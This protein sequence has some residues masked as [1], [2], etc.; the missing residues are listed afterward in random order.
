MSTPQPE[1]LWEGGSTLKLITHVFEIAL[2]RRNKYE[3]LFETLVVTFQQDAEKVVIMQDCVANAEAIKED[4]GHRRAQVRRQSTPA[5]PLL[6]VVKNIR[7]RKLQTIKATKGD[8]EAEFIVMADDD[9]DLQEATGPMV[10]KTPLKYSISKKYNTLSRVMDKAEK[11]KSIREFRRVLFSE[12]EVSALEKEEAE[13]IM[14]MQQEKEKKQTDKRFEEVSIQKEN[15]KLQMLFEIAFRALICE[16]EKRMNLF[17]ADGGMGEIVWDID[18]RNVGTNNAPLKVAATAMVAEAIQNKKADTL[19]PRALMSSLRKEHTKYAWF[20][21]MFLTQEA[22]IEKVR[23]F[24]TNLGHAVKTRLLESQEPSDKTYVSMLAIDKDV[25]E[26]KITPFAFLRARFEEQAAEA[27]ISD[28]RRPPVVRA[29]NQGQAGFT[30]SQEIESAV[31]ALIMKLGPISKSPNGEPKEEVQE[32]IRKKIMKTVWRMKD[33]AG[34]A[35]AKPKSA[36]ES[37]EDSEAEEMKA[38]QKRKQKGKESPKE[39]TLEEVVRMLKEQKGKLKALEQGG[40][41]SGDRK[42]PYNRSDDRKP[43]KKGTCFLFKG[44]GT[45]KFG[46][47]CH[48]EHVKEDEEKKP[49]KGKLPDPPEDACATLKRTGKCGD[50]HCAAKHGKWNKDSRRQCKK[51]EDGEC[52]KFLFLD[53]GCDFNHTE[54]KNEE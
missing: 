31:D 53:R 12:D 20:V 40:K 30:N 11:D 28:S 45:C 6:E 3:E 22:A 33:T 44:E 49:R 18:V 41:K 39:A 19:S 8:L 23:D 2:K 26:E 9:E 24:E 54:I 17:R 29:V 4:F 16:H 34:K 14:K 5:T 48:F 35:K 38:P 10:L 13:L 36:H 7:K 1:K 32:E 15:A 46:D 42:S 51:E 27:E 21:G 50:R 52:C 25:R 47:K 37:S 43:K